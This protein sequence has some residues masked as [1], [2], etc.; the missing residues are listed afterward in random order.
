MLSSKKYILQYIILKILNNDYDKNVLAPSENRLA[1]KFNCSRL[2]AR[3]ALIILV[4]IGILIAKQGMGYLVSE[5]AMDILFFAQKLKKNSHKTKIELI[6]KEEIESLIK[7]TV[8]GLVDTYYLKNYDLMDNLSSVTYLLI[9]KSS[10]K[11]YSDLA[12]NFLKNPI[13]EL[14]SMAIIPNRINTDLIVSNANFNNE[15]MKELLYVS[16]TPIPIISQEWI[17]SNG[18]WMIKTIN[19]MKNETHL[20]GTVVIL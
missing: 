10:V 3:S 16:K 4:N 15:D 6:E 17:D 5:K 19:I 9:N 2:T 1:I 13:E 12:S 8:N 14:I 11:T 18:I 7:T 20:F